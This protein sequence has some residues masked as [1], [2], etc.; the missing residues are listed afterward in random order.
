MSAAVVQFV[1]STTVLPFSLARMAPSGRSNWFKR[2][3]ACQT[4]CSAVSAGSTLG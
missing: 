2:W 1:K 4:H 3:N